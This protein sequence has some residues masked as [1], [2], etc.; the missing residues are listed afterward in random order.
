MK[1]E[2]IVTLISIPIKARDEVIGVMRLYY[3]NKREFTDDY[4]MLVNALANQGGLAIQNASL[5]LMLQE[6]KKNLEEEI[7][8][9]KQW[10]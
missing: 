7:W 6:D 9:H 8:S 1:K 3:G 4:I 10:F 2:K 5:Y